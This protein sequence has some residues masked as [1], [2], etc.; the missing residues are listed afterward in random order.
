MNLNS[1][2]LLIPKV[3]RAYVEASPLNYRLAH[4]T[5]WNVLGTVMPG[6]LTLI[7]SIFVARILGKTLFG[8]LGILQ[9]T[10]GMF[11]TFTG[12]GLGFTATKYIAEF[13]EKDKAKAARIISL[14]NLFGLLTGGV[15]SILVFIMAPWLSNH[16]LAAPHLTWILRTSVILVFLGTLVGVQTG[17]ISGFEAFKPLAFIKL[18]VILISF[19]FPISGAY[20]FGLSGVVWGLIAGMILNWMFNHLYLHRQTK[21]LGMSLGFSGIFHEF[22][23]LWKYSIP[24]ILGVMMGS[25]VI[26]ICNV[27]IVNQPNGYMEM[28]IYNAANQ[29]YMA[30]MV[31]PNILS[32]TG[33]PI[34]SEKLSQGNLVEAKKILSTSTRV[35]ALMIL[36]FAFLGCLLS[37][38][39]MSFYGT[40][41]SQGWLALVLSLFTVSILAFLVPVSTVLQASARMWI[42]FFLN[43]VWG[44]VFVLLTFLWAGYGSSGLAGAR[45]G[46]FGLHTLLTM[47]FVFSF[48]LGKG[49]GLSSR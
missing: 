31:V 6:V 12:L 21:R 36:P 30:L 4:G 26:W 40:G 2:T 35:N 19:P 8:E 28:G 32:Q 13:K 25:P 45:C 18:R 49:K 37:R 27:I 3:L 39:I 9:S 20:F 1:V 43:V 7:S 14:C 48:L 41:F 22:P 15:I 38:Q 11:G 23:V 47:T 46:A 44:A 17:I 10:I 24:A 29:W 42:L 33:L 5:F 16:V 34:F